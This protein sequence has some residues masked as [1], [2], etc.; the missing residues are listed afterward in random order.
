LIQAIQ[1]IV[2]EGASPLIHAQHLLFFV[3]SF[4]MQKLSFSL[5]AFLIRPAALK[6]TNLPLKLSLA[7]LRLLLIPNRRILTQNTLKYL[8]ILFPLFLSFGQAR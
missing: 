7:H 3:P 5:S 6:S 4:S 1:F 8:L 2:K